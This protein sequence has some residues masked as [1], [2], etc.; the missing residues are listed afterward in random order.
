MA[1][2][3]LDLS[4]IKCKEFLSTEKDN[5]ALLEKVCTRFDRSLEVFSMSEFYKSGAL[6]SCL[7]MPLKT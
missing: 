4:T 6:L 5:I 3:R 2:N 7:V 1:A